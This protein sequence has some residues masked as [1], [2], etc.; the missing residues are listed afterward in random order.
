MVT[1]LKGSCVGK[2]CRITATCT[3]LDGQISLSERASSLA[4]ALTLC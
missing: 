3:M 1:E 2:Y 4:V